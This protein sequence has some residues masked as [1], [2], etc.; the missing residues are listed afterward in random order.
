MNK[1]VL[2]P[3]GDKHNY[4][5]WAPYSWPNCTGIG[6]TTEL[7]PEEVWT[8]CPYY[9]RDGVFN[10]DRLLVNDTGH[11]SALSDAVLYNAIAWVLE[12][13]PSSK[14]SQTVAWFLHT[15]FI[16]PD[17]KMK[18]NLNFAQLARGPNG[19][20]GQ[21]TGV[22]DLKSFAKIVSGILILRK[23]VSPDWTTELDNEMVAWA[24]E[25]IPWLETNK[26]ALGEATATNNHGSFYYNQLAS[27]KLL[28]NDKAGALNVT[29]TYFSKQYL[30]QIEASGEQPLEAA[31]TRPY[32]YRAYNLA[33]MITNARIAVYADPSATPFNKTT[34]SGAN[35]KT[36]LDFTMTLSPSTS[37]E[38][39]AAPELFPCVAAVASVYGDPDGKYA[40]FLS[41]SESTYAEDAYF[42]WD[43]PLAGGS[44]SNSS[45][46]NQGT[47]NT[48][49]SGAL[50]VLT[51]VN[52]FM[53][54]ISGLL[55]LAC[56]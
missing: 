15:W 27:L 5:S 10:P 47:S 40:A 32:H 17:T 18:P 3:S 16:N 14:Y 48:K 53:L 41:N 20:V 2:P 9:T 12:G 36:A 34:S 19:Q 52:Y 44:A 21:H 13:Q 51:R 6:N 7:P 23:G 33:A 43:Q 4:L 54:L 42:L 50:G 49:D 22:L 35:I 45:S 26:I 37:N 28:V 30:S 24:N 25:Y 1:T 38:E 46:P 29:E 39:D 55:V 8:K 56:I 31:R 11:F